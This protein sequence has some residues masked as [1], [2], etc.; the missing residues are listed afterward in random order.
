MLSLS[1]SKRIFKG[2]ERGVGKNFSPSHA[3]DGSP[4]FSLSGSH[5]V[6]GERHP[7]AHKNRESFLS[8]FDLTA[9]LIKMGTE[10]PESILLSLFLTPFLKSIPFDHPFVGPKE[11]TLTGLRPFVGHWN[12]FFPHSLFQEV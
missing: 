8:L 7:S 2:V 9:P 5:R 10:V 11:N 12:N 3:S 6:F 1:N 4:L